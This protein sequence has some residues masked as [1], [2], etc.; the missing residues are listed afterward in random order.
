MY[1]DRAARTQGRDAADFYELLRHHASTL[2]NEQLYDIYPDAMAT[3]EFR[4]EPSGGWILSRQVAEMMD[5]RLNQWLAT[6]L[7]PGA[8]DRLLDGMLREYRRI[9]PD[10]QRSEASVLLSAFERGLGLA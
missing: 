2:T 10:D 6:I 4:P 1:G 8:R 7:A 9:E 5:G 3:Y